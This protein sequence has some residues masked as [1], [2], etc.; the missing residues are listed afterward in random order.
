ML[1]IGAAGQEPGQHV[2]VQGRHR[3]GV[4]VQLPAVALQQPGRQH[5]EP[6]PHG[7][8]DGL[9]EGVHIHHPPGGIDALERGDG[10]AGKA[11][12]TVVVVL[13]D[14]AVRPLRPPQQGLPPADGGH[15]PGGVVVGRGEVDRAGPRRIQ[16]LRRHALAVQRHRAADR[17][18]LAVHLADAGIARV[19]HGQHRVPAQQLG[20]QEVQV[21]RPGAHH[22]LFRRHRH[23]LVLPQIPGDGL[24]Q[25][26]EPL[27]GHRL[28]QGLDVL[29]QHPAG[30]AGP[31]GDGKAGG[32]HPVAPQIQPPG[33][34]LRHLRRDRGGGGGERQLLHRGGKKAPPGPDGQVS[35]RLQLAV[36]R[37]HRHDGDMQ[38]LRQGPLG[39]QPLPGGQGAVQ[40]VPPDA[41]VQVLVKGQTAPVLHHIGAHGV[42]SS[43]LIKLSET[44]YF[45]HTTP[46]L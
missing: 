37:L 25:D 2:L 34:S 35:L 7:G 18:P 16:R 33:G 45:H 1:L 42:S 44:G 14:D 10:P 39:G 6:H 41:A 21:L 28:E 26:G 40:N 29:R 23:A 43:D 15:Q 38:M 9:G 32:V 31:G 36:G 20:Q 24:P 12:F 19:L 4:E 13:D 5:H 22:D 30:E 17:P 11:E 8:G 46:A 27:M 3:A